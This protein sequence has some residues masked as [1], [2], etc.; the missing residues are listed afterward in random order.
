MVMKEFFKKNLLIIIF[1]VVGAT[2]GFLYWKFVGCLSG[3]CVIK[4][5]W[6]LST[7]YGTAMGWIFGS[8]AADLFKSF[9]KQK[10][11]E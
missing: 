2:G 7:L 4:S 8:L 9:K 1:S 6:Y 11:Y 10:N 5:V 3:T